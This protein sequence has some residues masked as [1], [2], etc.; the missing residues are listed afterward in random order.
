MKVL[1]FVN[2]AF[3]SVKEYLNL[4]PNYN[5][6]W[7]VSLSEALIL[8]STIS[9]EIVWV[10]EQIQQYSKFNDGKLTYYLIPKKL[11]IQS[12]SKLSKLLNLLFKQNYNLPL[13]SC[14]DL[15]NK[16]N[17]DIIHVHGTEEFYGLLNALIKKPFVI[18][19]QGLLGACYT[20][21]WGKTS[22]LKRLFLMREFYIWIKMKKSLEIENE[23][24]KKNTHFIGRTDFDKSYVK[25]INPG[26][27]YFS[28]HETMRSEFYV[29]FWSYQK[30]NLNNLFTTTTFLPYKGIDTLIRAVKILKQENFQI[31]LR[32]CG[33]IPISGYGRY[34]YK[35]ISKL[36][37]NNSIELLGYLSAKE[38][39]SE[40][41][42]ANIFILPSFI[43]NSPNS[44]VESLLMGVPSIGPN[45]GG[46]PS[47][48]IPEYNGL[49]FT[50]GNYSELA[51]KI[52]Q[53]LN[54]PEFCIYLGSNAR[55]MA[56]TRNNPQIISDR[57]LSLY[58]ELIS[59]SKYTKQ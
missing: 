3:P 52:A 55:K 49:L 46:V 44:L 16:I 40:L 54:S 2:C 26:A 38:I 19:I 12:N 24:I 35:L 25:Q 48:I 32:I 23:I 43:E 15:I 10:S 13:S 5:G 39:V 18:S 21:F 45:T 8:N 58:Q 34:I 33:Q 42:R 4:N 14:V 22:V 27:N 41:L 56:L 36:G 9:L 20:K 47:F 7:M 11:N 57:T 37:L 53:L 30:E 17:P 28:I 51:T 50:P 29:N 31:K 6:W 1:W 59:R